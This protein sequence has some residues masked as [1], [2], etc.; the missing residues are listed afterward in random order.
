MNCNTF[1]QWMESYAA[2]KKNT[3]ININMN[4]Y[5][6]NVVLVRLLSIKYLR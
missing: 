6:Q 5:G 1:L 2:M 3:N 4:G